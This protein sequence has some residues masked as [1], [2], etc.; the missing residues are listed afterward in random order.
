MG[1]GLFS[2]VTSDKARRLD[3]RKKFSTDKVIKHWDKQP[4]EVAELPS[5]EV[6]KRH[7]DGTLKDMV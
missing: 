7:M 1:I 4:R 3:I 2:H 6:L 5:L